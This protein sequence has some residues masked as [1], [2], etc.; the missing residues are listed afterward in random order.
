MYFT[1]LY[2]IDNRDILIG[3]KS[4]SFYRIKLVIYCTSEFR[5][6]I[7]KVFKILDNLRNLCRMK[8]T[9]HNRFRMD[10][11]R[12]DRSY[13]FCLKIPNVLYTPFLL[14]VLHSKQNYTP[15]EGSSISKHFHYLLL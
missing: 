14:N 13:S 7:A 9:F 4:E 10:R 15:F 12:T 5:N 1:S 3:R 8:S 6:W 11:S 2:K